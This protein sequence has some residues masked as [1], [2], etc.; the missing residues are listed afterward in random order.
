MANISQLA[1][2]D[3]AIKTHGDNNYPGATGQPNGKPEPTKTFNRY[4]DA[5]KKLLGGKAFD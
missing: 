2:A 1:F 4:L 5:I 3:H